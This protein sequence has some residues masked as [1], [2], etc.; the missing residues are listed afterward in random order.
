M[1]M[2][3][4]LVFI[5]GF[6]RGGVCLCPLVI[7]FRAILAGDEVSG[8]RRIGILAQAERGWMGEVWGEGRGSGGSRSVDRDPVSDGGA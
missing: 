1:E 5:P 7:W 6:G 3:V 8:L 2:R 4:V